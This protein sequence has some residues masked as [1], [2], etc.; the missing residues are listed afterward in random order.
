MA[1]SSGDGESWI[2]ASRRPDGTW[3]KARKVKEGYVPQDEVAK[4]ESKGK[5]W[6]NSIPKL[7]P[8]LH[9][10]EPTKSQRKR[11]NKKK[12]ASE[13]QG[14]EVEDLTDKMHSVHVSNAVCSTAAGTVYTSNPDELKEKR[15]KNLRKKLRQIKELQA[16]IDSGELEKPEPEQ[17]VKLSKKEEVEK[18]IE[19]L[20]AQLCKS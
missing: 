15:I 20:Q 2:P 6:M 18:E 7:P 4:Y 9:I 12:N 14:G 8:G 16:R 10:E 11:K 3:R 1:S 13:S 5:Q 19:D 17:L